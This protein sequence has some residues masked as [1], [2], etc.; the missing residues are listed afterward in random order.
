VLEWKQFLFSVILLLQVITAALAML[1]ESA[2]KCFGV[3]YC[4]SLEFVRLERLSSGKGPVVPRKV[5]N[6]SRYH[7]AIEVVILKKKEMA[8]A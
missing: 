8:F 1:C 3:N 7:F 2:N 4:T 6:T 5:S